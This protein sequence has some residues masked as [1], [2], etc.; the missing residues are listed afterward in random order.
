VLKSHAAFYHSETIGSS[1]RCIKVKLHHKERL[2]KG[3][4]TGYS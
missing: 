3:E 4:P 2:M 1:L